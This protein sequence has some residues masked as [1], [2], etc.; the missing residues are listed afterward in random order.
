MPKNTTCPGV[1]W[2]TDPITDQ[3]IAETAAHTKAKPR[4]RA[5]MIE[6]RAAGLAK[7]T[8]PWAAALKSQ[9]GQILSNFMKYP[10]HFTRGNDKGDQ[11]TGDFSEPLVLLFRC[12]N[13]GVHT[14]VSPSWR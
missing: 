7:Q 3:E 14:T 12:L 9:K 1:P 8:L 13:R 6:H 5:Y 11:G 2:V 4:I 10:A